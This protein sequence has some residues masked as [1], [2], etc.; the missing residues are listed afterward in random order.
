MYPNCRYHWGYWV[1]KTIIRLRR[2]LCMVRLW[3]RLLIMDDNRIT[4][5]ISLWS[6]RNENMWAREIKNIFEMLDLGIC[7]ESVSMCDFNSVQNKIHS[8]GVRNWEEEIIIKPKLKTYITFIN[9]FGTESFITNNISRRKRSLRRRF[10]SGILPIHV[11]TG[12]FRNLPVD[13]RVCEICRNGK[14][15]DICASVYFDRYSSAQ[16]SS[17]HP[18]IE[19]ACGNMRM[20]VF[21]IFTNAHLLLIWDDHFVFLRWIFGY[22][23]VTDRPLHL[24]YS[25]VNNSTMSYDYVICLTYWSQDKLATIR[26]RQL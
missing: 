3:N 15:E 5:T 12:R 14:V 24:Y 7:Y 13:I 20:C 21:R 4:K 1:D 10:R 23:Q 9:T 8:L 17:A 11:E 16:C 2:Y 22:S 25:D 26:Q 19:K 6:P 18:L